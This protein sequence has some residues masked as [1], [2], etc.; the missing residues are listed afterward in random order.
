MKDDFEPFI[1]TSEL[2][3]AR[4]VLKDAYETVKDTLFVSDLTKTCGL[5]Y[6]LEDKNLKY[7][8]VIDIDKIGD[9]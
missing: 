6:K 2:K 5:S 1:I 9:L 8:V 4:K 3:K 7:A